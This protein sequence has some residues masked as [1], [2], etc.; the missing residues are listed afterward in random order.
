MSPAAFLSAAFSHWG[1]PSSRRI[2]AGVSSGVLC[3]VFL[4]IGRSCAKWILYHGE[5]GTGAMGALVFSGGLVATL[6]GIAYRKP[7]E[8]MPPTP[9]LET[10]SAP[11][12]AATVVVV[13][14]PATSLVVSETFPAGSDKR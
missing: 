5:L 4:A 13:G 6:A 9:L 12:G 8:T 2:I 1:T 10:A 3:I 7:D 14:T 11:R